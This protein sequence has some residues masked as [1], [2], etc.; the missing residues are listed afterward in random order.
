[1]TNVRHFVPC[2]TDGCTLIRRARGLCK[3]HYERRFRAGDL[4]PL[5]T[6]EERFWKFVDV[7]GEDECWQWLGDGAKRG[8]GK[9]QFKGRR[10]VAHR[11]AFEL[12]GLTVPDGLVL[13]HLCRNRACVNPRHLEPVTNGENVLRGVGFSAVNAAKTHCIHGHEFNAINTYWTREGYRSCRVCSQ[14]SKRA[15]K[16]IA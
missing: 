13:D 2:S 7:R 8:Y 5:V 15:K 12:N 3:T 11:V 16:V 4:P 1:M 6:L 10:H 9:F 14:V